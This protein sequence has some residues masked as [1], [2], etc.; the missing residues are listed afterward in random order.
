MEATKELIQ[1]LRQKTGAGLAD[2]K[3]ALESSETF[4][5]AIDKLRYKLLKA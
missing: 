2:S 5:E 3:L 4:E 1:E